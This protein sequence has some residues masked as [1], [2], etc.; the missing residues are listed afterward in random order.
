M[1]AVNKLKRV[2]HAKDEKIVELNRVIET[3]R[4]FARK[5][6]VEK[7]ALEKELR[8]LRVQAHI[9]HLFEIEDC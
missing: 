8:S 6:E 1:E 7:A 3:E 9:L 4:A 2:S 5:S